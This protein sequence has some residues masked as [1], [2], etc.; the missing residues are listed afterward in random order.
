MEE[1]KIS[2]VTSLLYDCTNDEVQVIISQTEDP[3]VLYMYAYNYNWDNGFEIPQS[4]LDHN[5]CNL[6]IALLIFYRAD[7]AS[8]LLNKS[9]SERLPQWSSFIKKLYETI[10]DEKYQKVEIEFKAPLSKVEL[11]KLKK[12]LSEQEN[13]FIENIEGKNLNIDL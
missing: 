8:Y 12:I 4:I 11:Y 1:N 2:R 7:G 6:S 10:I 13:V 3:E 5:K 9:Y